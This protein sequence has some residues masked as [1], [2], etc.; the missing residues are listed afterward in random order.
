[1]QGPQR[2]AGAETV[3]T[4]R[5]VAVTMLPILRISLEL[6]VAIA[7]FSAGPQRQSMLRLLIAVVGLVQLI[8]PHKVVEMYTRLAY[9]GPEAFR[10]RQ[11][12]VPAIRLEGLMML[13][14]AVNGFDEESAEQLSEDQ[15][16]FAK[17]SVPDM[18]SM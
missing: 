6:P 12:V 3:G 17:A 10:V 9:E 13:W 8:A 2:T 11:W 4:F 14:L 15:A 5:L 7:L 16:S 1:M 18:F